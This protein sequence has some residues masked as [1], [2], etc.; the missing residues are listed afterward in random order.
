MFCRELGLR[1]KTSTTLACFPFPPCG[2]SVIPSLASVH[3]D[4]CT[5]G[6]VF[7]DLLR[8]GLSL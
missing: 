3:L 1:A 5:R 2:I 8:C 6:G 7:S 4:V